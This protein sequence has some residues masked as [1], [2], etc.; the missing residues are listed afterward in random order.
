MS[1]QGNLFGLGTRADQI[2]QRFVEFHLAN[3]RVWVLF[4]QFADRMRKHRDHYSA[5]AIFEVIR[6]ETDIRTTG[7]PV[8]MNDHYTVYYARMYHAMHPEADGFF[9]VRRRP[10]AEKPAYLNDVVVFHTGDPGEE[11][12]LMARLRELGSRF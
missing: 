11:S 2:F 10:S 9:N 7:E 6:Y 3:P 5:H 12:A 4:C 8:K 1:D